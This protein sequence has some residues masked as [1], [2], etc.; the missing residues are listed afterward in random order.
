MLTAEAVR[1][2]LVVNHELFREAL[3]YALN[4]EPVL[5]VIGQASTPA[6]IL[7]D[8]STGMAEVVVMESRV[9]GRDANT[10][11]AGL[12]SGLRGMNPR[13]SVLVLTDDTDIVRQARSLGASA[14]GLLTSSATMEDIL[15]AVKRLADASV[16]SRR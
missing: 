8:P 9:P 15:D 12:V 10:P 3:A 5:W 2:V 4:G 13:A 16:E 11:V 14:D 6:D 7:D 1:V